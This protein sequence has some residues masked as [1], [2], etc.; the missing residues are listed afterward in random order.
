MR[1][2]Y[3]D[4][5]LSSENWKGKKE[6]RKPYRNGGAVD[7]RCRPHGE[8]YWCKGN[9]LHSSKKREPIEEDY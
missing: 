4:N 1:K 8:C 9:R 7:T 3:F 2:S 5:W 6:R